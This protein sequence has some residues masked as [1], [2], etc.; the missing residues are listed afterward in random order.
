MTKQEDSAQVLPHKPLLTSQQ[1]GWSDVFLTYYHHPGRETCEHLMHQH[2]LEVTDMVSWAEHERRLDGQFKSYRFGNGEIG[3]C[4]AN[5]SHWTVWDQEFHFT[6]ILFEPRLLEQV[7]H[8]SVNGDRLEF[9][10]QFQLVDPVIQQIA[11]ALKAD[12]EAGCPAGRLYGESFSAAL[13]VHLVTTCS[14]FQQKIPAYPD[15]LPKYKLQQATDYIQAYLDRDIKLADLANTVRMSP[16]YFCR[17]FKQSMSMTPHQYVI[18]QRV[19]RAKQL[20]KQPNALIA[21]VALQCGFAHQ[22]H[23]SQHFRRLVGMSPKTFQ[24]KLQESALNR[25]NLRDI[26]G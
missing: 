4:P 12:L 3:F 17:L 10:P 1:A 22:S 15:G 7:A 13:A 24:G 23:L 14:V 16:Y 26:S 6:L 20:L 18:Q 5:T 11:S 9:I 19:E 21:D 2:V 25:K 8:E